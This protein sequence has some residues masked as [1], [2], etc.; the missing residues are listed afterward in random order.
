MLQMLFICASPFFCDVQR[1]PQKQYIKQWN[2]LAVLPACDNTVKI[3]KKHAP[4]NV[5]SVF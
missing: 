2:L 1:I 4:A 3:Y 5:R